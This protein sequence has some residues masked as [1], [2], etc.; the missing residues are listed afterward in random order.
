MRDLAALQAGAVL[1]RESLQAA[2]RV[3]HRDGQRVELLL[4]AFGERDIDN[5]LG[6]VE[7]EIG[8]GMIP[9]RARD[10]RVG[11]CVVEGTAMAMCANSG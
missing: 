6:S 1:R 9:L 5:L 3:Q 7:R 4:E 10:L 11:G 2:P 8:H